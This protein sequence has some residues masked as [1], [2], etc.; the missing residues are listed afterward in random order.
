MK[1]LTAV[2]LPFVG[3]YRTFLMAP[4]M[5]TSDEFSNFHTRSPCYANSVYW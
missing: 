3:S 4:G 5:P 2:W 1:L